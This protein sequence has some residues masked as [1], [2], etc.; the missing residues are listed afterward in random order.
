MQFE[1]VD[2]ITILVFFFSLARAENATS[3]LSM[4]TRNACQEI[5]QKS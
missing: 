1:S 3:R 2:E 4:R 5:P